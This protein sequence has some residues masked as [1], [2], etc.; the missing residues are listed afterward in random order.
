MSQTKTQ[1]AKKKE[2]TISQPGKKSSNFFLYDSL[3]TKG[4]VME[5]RSH[6][7]SEV[8]IIVIAIQT[9]KYP[10][11]SGPDRKYF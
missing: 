3:N 5:N 7:S 9:Q 11:P 8:T 2:L 1:S 6:T 10:Y 4:F